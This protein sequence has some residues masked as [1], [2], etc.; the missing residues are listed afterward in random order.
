MDLMAEASLPLLGE[1][2][3][4]GFMGSGSSVRN[5]VRVL[6]SVVLKREKFFLV[7]S[8]K[9]KGFLKNMV[10]NITGTLVDVA[11][12]KME[13]KGLDAVLADRDRRKAG[14]CAPG[15]GLYLCGVE[16]LH[17]TYKGEIPFLLDL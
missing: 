14:R 11:L 9:G 13:R 17:G 15:D 1:H 2:D 12:G 5:T 7:L 8:C 10:R 3:F 16:Y 6:E 4:R